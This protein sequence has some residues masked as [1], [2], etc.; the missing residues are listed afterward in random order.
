M[1]PSVALRMELKAKKLAAII[2]TVNGEMKLENHRM[3]FEN[4]QSKSYPIPLSG[5]SLVMVYIKE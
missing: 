5:N 3:T 4:L 1:D 2:I